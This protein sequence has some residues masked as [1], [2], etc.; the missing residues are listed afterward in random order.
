MQPDQPQ[1]GPLSGPAWRRAARAALSRQAAAR[2]A[3]AGTY[4]PKARRGPGAAYGPGM[5][6][7]MPPPEAAEGG[8]ET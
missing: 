3:R 7:R 5:A 8:D 2:R 6:R 4:T 1:P